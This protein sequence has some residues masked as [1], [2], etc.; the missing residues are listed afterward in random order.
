MRERISTVSHT[1]TDFIFIAH[2]NP[3]SAPTQYAYLLA[4]YG[5]AAGHCPR[6]HDAYS[7][8]RLAS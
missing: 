8:K 2:V 4:D 3:V 6:V 1:D 5:G 7:I